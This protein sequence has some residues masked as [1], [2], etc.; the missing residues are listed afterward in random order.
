MFNLFRTRDK[1]VRYLLTALLSLVALSMVITLIP[2]FG[3]D[4]GSQSDQ[5][6]AQIGSEALTTREV[7]ATVQNAIRGRQVP[8]EMVQ[9]Y[10]PQVI[11]QLISERAVAWQAQQMGFRV[12]DEETAE[13]IRSMLAQYFPG[14]IKREDYQ[15]FLAQQGM[16]VEQFEHNVRRNLLMLR[17]QNIA[18]EGAVVTPDEVEREFRRKND[19]VKVEYVKYTAPADLASQV[20]V[21]PEEIRQAYETQKATL[22]S[23]ERRSFHM[24]IADEAKIGAAVQVSEEQLRAAYNSSLDRFRTPERVH[25]RHILIK[26]TD[27]PAADVPKAE[28]KANDLLKQIKAGGDF[29]A[30]AKQHSDDPGSKE[31]GG[32]LDWVTRGQ[33]VPNFEKA[34]FTLQPKQ[35]SDVIKTEY[36]FHILQVLEKE[37]A[38]VQPFEAVRDQLAAEIRREAVYNNMQQ[39]VEQAR[40]E[41]IRNPKDAEQ[42]AAKH[43][44]AYYN[45]QKVRATDSLPEIGTN[46]DLSGT[47]FSLRTGEVS[48][49]AQVMPTRLA[50]AQVTEIQPPRPAELSEVE[51]DLR[52]Q[53]TSRKVQQLTEEKIRQATDTLKNAGGDLRA[54]A[55]QIGSEVKTTD[56]F[57]IEGAAEGIGPATALSDAFTKP[58]GSVIGPVSVGGQVVL[59]KVVEKQPADMA[60]LAATRNEVVLQL[61]RRKAAERKE[62][63]EDGLITQLIRE[64]KVKKFP[65]AIN[66]VVQSYRG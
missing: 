11:D 17:L 9:F 57:T 61:K 43:G 41:L 31:K 26:T 54:A 15:R 7:Q 5:I 34:A 30:L 25:V 39:A 35:V 37:Q 38:K 29:A 3:S 2:G 62:L 33:T 55:K 28:A 18:L 32:D 50:I 53:I 4:M 63:F 8:Q 52:T 58:V 60:Q 13:A 14:E 19:K 49:P 22:M 20:T 44:L 16:T 64:G 48:Q 66:R 27:M 65:E 36:G 1:A 42:I 46:S 10:V 6:V 12:S 23:P 59:A 56:F 21:T 24:L 51:N 45:V 40:A 47:V